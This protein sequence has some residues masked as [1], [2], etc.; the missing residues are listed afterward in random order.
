MVDYLKGR[1]RMSVFPE[2]DVIKWDPRWNHVTKGLWKK[3]QVCVKHQPQSSITF[4]C[5]K[6][7]TSITNNLG[8]FE[9]QLFSVSC[10][11]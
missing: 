1:E 6:L 5:P 2:P 8:K 3:W 4:Q 11:H 9:K 7:P 10:E